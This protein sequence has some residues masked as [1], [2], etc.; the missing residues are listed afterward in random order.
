MPVLGARL[1]LNRNPRG[2]NGLDLLDAVRDTIVRYN[3]IPPGHRVL[4]AVSGGPD[5]VALLH[6]LLRL[7]EDLSIALH[8]FHMDHG[9]RRDSSDDAAFVE[10]IAREWRLPITVV[11]RN[12]GHERRPR[13]SIQQAARRIR[14]AAMRHVA[15]HVD[16]QRIALGHQTDDQAETVLMRLIRGSGVTGL[17][18]MRRRRGPY[19]RPLLELTR[20]DIMAYCDAF[21]LEFREDPSNRSTRYLRN[22][23]RLEL[24]PLLT[25]EYNPNIRLT[26]NR[27]AAL[28]QD[29]DD[30]LELLAHKAFRRMQDGQ[31][32]GGRGEAGHQPGDGHDR[33]VHLSVRDLLLQPMALR[34]R[35]VRHA[36]RH[37]AGTLLAVTY[38]HIEAVLALLD[39]DVG[40]AVNLPRRVRVNRGHDALVFL[41]RMDRTNA[42]GGGALRAENPDRSNGVGEGDE[43]ED[44]AAAEF[45]VPMVV[46]GRTVIPGNTMIDAAFIEPPPAGARPGKDEAWFDWEKLLPP[47]VVRTWR[48]GDRMR[49]LGLGGTKKLQDVFVDDKIPAVA[50]RSVPIVVDRAGI[51][52]VA[53]VRTD[54]RA[55]VGPRSRRVL[56]L[57]ITSL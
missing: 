52:W 48:P 9:L 35:I 51:I 18:G 11:R 39:A 31:S 38:E 46:P 13:E 27:T 44:Q 2:E 28:L 37:V 1:N 6:L 7:S 19:I 45:Q 41:Q 12:V 10:R 17:G 53:N 42:A 34:R 25:A 56:Q 20:A 24:L 3:L 32:E 5:S 43:R 21:R 15:S 49:P 36:L 23:I 30:L 26:L 40:A 57:R 29:D 54:E 14:Y 22:K 47:L 33:S 4:V 8:T 50:R 16:A 55:A